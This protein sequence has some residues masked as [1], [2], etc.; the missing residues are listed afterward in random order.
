MSFKIVTKGFEIDRIDSSIDG[1]VTFYAS[2]A[3]MPAGEDSEKRQGY[4]S[5]AFIEGLSGGAANERGEVTL[6]GMIR[7]LDEKVR[8]ASEGRQK[9]F[10]VVDGYN[11][12]SLILNTTTK[13][14][15]P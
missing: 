15:Q 12:S 4:F 1:Y 7:Y 5:Y 2:H 13:A 9:P 10:T 11:A 14:R 3:G 8:N 6:E